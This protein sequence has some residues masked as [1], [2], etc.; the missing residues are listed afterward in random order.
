MCEKDDEARYHDGAPVSIL[1]EASVAD[2]NTRLFTKDGSYSDRGTEN[3]ISFSVPPGRFRPNI[4][5]KVRCSLCHR[6]SF[7]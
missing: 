4:V 5:V 1:S 7:S 2:L 3:M 6:N